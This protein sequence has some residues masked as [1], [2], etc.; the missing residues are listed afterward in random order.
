MPPP[1][2]STSTSGRPPSSTAPPRC[3][4]T[5]TTARPRPSTRRTSRSTSTSPYPQFLTLVSAGLLRHPVADRAAHPHPGGELREADRLRRLHRAEWRKGQEVVFKRNPNYTS[6]PATAKHQGPAYVDELRWK[7]VRRRAL[8]LRLADHRAERRRLR[9]PHR[10]LEGRAGAFAPRSATSRPASPCRSSSTPPR[11]SSPTS[12]SGR[13]SPRRRP[14]GR[15]RG[16][17]PRRHPLR[18][19]PVGQ[20]VDAR[21][22]RR[23]RRRVPVRPGQG[24]HS[25]STR[26]AGP[27]ATPTA[28]APR[29]GSRCR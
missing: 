3:R 13:P 8:A 1:W 25:C 17:L 16:R 2:P 20:P 4:S 27:P 26:P 10:E 11:A 12:W 24:E 22:Q 18:G 14:Q 5:R 9:D 15:G 6:W 21:L 19:Q 23:H 29:T 7:F 28:S